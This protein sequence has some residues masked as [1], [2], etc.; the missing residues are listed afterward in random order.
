MEEMRRPLNARDGVLA[1]AVLVGAYLGWLGGLVTGTRPQAVAP[2]TSPTPAHAPSSPPETSSG[3]TTPPLA[4]G[5]GSFFYTASSPTRHTSAEGKRAG[6]AMFDTLEAQDLSGCTEARKIWAEASKREN[7]GGE[8][9]ALDWLCQ[10]LAADARAR[11]RMM[12]DRDGARVVRYFEQVGWVELQRYLANRYEFATAANATPTTAVVAPGSV[13]TSPD[14]TVPTN[15]PRQPSAGTQLMDRDAF[16][17]VH[18]ILRF[19]GPQRKVWEHSAELLAGLEITPG[20]VV[21]D[22]GSGHGYFSYLFSDAV[23]PGGTVYALELGRTFEDFMQ[24]VVKEEGLTNIQSVQSSKTSV[25]LPDDSVDLIFI[26]NLYHEI[27]GGMREAEREALIGSMRLALRPG[28]RLVV[29]D[30][31]PEAEQA[32]GTLYYHGFAISPKLV[33]PQLEGHG[34]ELQKQVA[35][36]PQRYELVFV[37]AEPR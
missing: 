37:E 20:M 13:A 19:A 5:T 35:Y 9:G 26:C 11:T 2:C 24:K 14:G 18:E 12:K 32:A 25:N 3:H 8:Y 1:L 7:F 10:Y 33:I 16:L 36:I 21:A 30:N 27:Y 4:A 34:F 17:F 28:G 29:V 6:E 22:V 23:G 15:A 31:M